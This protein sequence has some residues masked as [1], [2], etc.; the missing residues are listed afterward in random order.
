MKNVL[1]TRTLV[2][3][4][5]LGLTGLSYFNIFKYIDPAYAATPCIVTLF[6]VQYDVSPLQTGHTGGNIFV[7]GTDMTATYQGMHG[8]N[9]SRMVSYLLTSPSPSPSVSPSL[10]P[11]PS[12]SVSP[13]PSTSP[14][15][16]PSVSPS[17]TPSPSGSP[18]S[19]DDD[20][21]ENENEQAEEHESESRKSDDRHDNRERRDD[22]EEDSIASLNAHVTVR[23]ADHS[24]N[25]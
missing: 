9:V 20:E 7:C 16:S 12:P 6:G 3:V 1:L 2:A 10:S 18:I 4:S 11:S 21:E 8:T 17:S 23:V 13:S 15:P 24:D 19:H 22:G 5:A 14:S 25:D